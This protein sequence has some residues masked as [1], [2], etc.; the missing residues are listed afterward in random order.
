MDFIQGFDR[1]QLQMISFDTFVKQD[2]WARIVDL[3]VDIL[4]LKDLGF[5]D[6]PEEEGRPPFHPADM[7]KLY[8]YGYKNHLR[9]SRKLAHAC[10]NNLA[11]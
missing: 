11:T 3:F 10:Q 1:N 7:L 8:L 2:S 4:P 6:T 5:I 9:S